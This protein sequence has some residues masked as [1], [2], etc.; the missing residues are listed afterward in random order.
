M[1]CAMSAHVRLHTLP[2]S[3]DSDSDARR[4]PSDAPPPPPGED[5]PLSAAREHET[6]LAV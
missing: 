5:A 1:Y 4:P 6:E 2:L 3:F